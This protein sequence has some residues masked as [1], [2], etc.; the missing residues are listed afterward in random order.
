[1]K[2]ASGRTRHSAE[3][4]KNREPRTFRKLVKLS[5]GGK[6]SL[7]E[8][9]REALTDKGLLDDDG[10]VTRGVARLLAEIGTEPV[11]RR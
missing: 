6:A 4:L 8:S 2:R 5:E 7:G 9:E 11:L 1:M 10:R 3:T